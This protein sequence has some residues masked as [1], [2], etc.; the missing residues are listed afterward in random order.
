MPAQADPVVSSR[1]STGPKRALTGGVGAS[2]SAGRHDPIRSDP[3]QAP[4]RRRRRE[5]RYC[6]RCRFGSCGNRSGVDG[7]PNSIIQAVKPW[8][9][10]MDIV[11]TT[12]RA[13]TFFRVRDDHRVSAP[14][15]S[16]KPGRL[17][18]DEPHR[19]GGWV[20]PLGRA[21]RRRLKRGRTRGC[22][23]DRLVDMALHALQSSRRRPAQH[24]R[25]R[26]CGAGSTASGQDRG[27]P[28]GS[29]EL[30]L[31]RQRNTCTYWMLGPAACSQRTHKALTLSSDN[32]QLKHEKGEKDYQTP[33]TLLP[34]V[35]WFL[36]SP[37]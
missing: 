3:A 15:E 22:S 18:L 8:T 5:N 34:S 23:S 17:L 31:T 16:S 28:G 32:T 13:G 20:W 4:A 21:G 2:V 14:A 6:A 36:P 35:W 37:E 27:K 1:P 29:A 25:P 9:P 24:A 26:C 7:V 30:T 11:E 33:P 19:R 10:T 12:A